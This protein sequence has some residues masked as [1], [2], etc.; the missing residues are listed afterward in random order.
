MFYAGYAEGSTKSCFFYNMPF[1]FFMVTVS[2][3]KIMT[4]CL[5]ITLTLAELS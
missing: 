1:L 4:T 2:K 5:I 3:T